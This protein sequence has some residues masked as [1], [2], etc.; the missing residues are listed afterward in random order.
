MEYVLKQDKK[1]EY[2]WKLVADNN[3]TLAMSSEGYKNRGDCEHAISL[4]QGSQD[5]TIR[6]EEAAAEPV[7]VAVAETV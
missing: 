7:A 1:N 5:A 4:V 2:R 3:K 6:V